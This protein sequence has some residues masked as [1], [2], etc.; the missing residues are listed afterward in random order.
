[1]GG[2]FVDRFDEDSTQRKETFDHWSFKM[3]AKRGLQI[4]D[5][6]PK[7]HDRTILQDSAQKFLEKYD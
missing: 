7:E 4:F 1:M 5:K 6:S 3:P 2:L